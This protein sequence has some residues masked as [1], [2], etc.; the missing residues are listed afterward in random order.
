MTSKLCCT[1][2]RPFSPV[3]PC[4]RRIQLSV[5]E[6]RLLSTQASGQDSRFTSTKTEELQAL[7][8]I[9][10][11]TNAEDAGV[12]K[13]NCASSICS[14]KTARFVSFLRRKL[15]RD[16]TKSK[17]DLQAE[18]GE[19]KRLKQDIRQ[20]LM[21]DQGPDSGGYD[22]DALMLENVDEIDIAELGVFRYRGRRNSRPGV[23]DVQWAATAPDRYAI[24]KVIHLLLMRR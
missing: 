12:A 24:L 16:K 9:F 14:S 8:Q 10:A 2:E 17:R 7:R 23:Q 20:N 4:S 21:S 3:L 22:I 6:Q 5:G 1:D 11:N 15:S 18:P 19:L 13:H